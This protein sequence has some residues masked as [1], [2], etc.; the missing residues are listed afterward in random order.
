MQS[1]DGGGVVLQLV[2]D[3]LVLL[4]QRLDVRFV[5]SD[6][7]RRHQPQD[8]QHPGVDVVGVGQELVSFVVIIF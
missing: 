5:L 1:V 2:G 7:V 4:Q 3:V 6:V 8:V